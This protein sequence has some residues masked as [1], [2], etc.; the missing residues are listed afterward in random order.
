MINA[1]NIKSRN[2]SI[3]GNTNSEGPYLA[4]LKNMHE[5]QQL[6]TEATYFF[7]YLGFLSQTFTIQ[8]TAGEGGGYLFNSS[9]PLTPASQTL[10]Y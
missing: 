2:W 1:F 3:N 9:L 8:K 10:R 7:F 4:F 5:L 6:I